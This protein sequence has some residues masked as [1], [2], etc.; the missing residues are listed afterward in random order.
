MTLIAQQLYQLFYDADHFLAD[1]NT[2]CESEKDANT[3]RCF[4]R[5]I[6][7]IEGNKLWFY[8]ECKSK[9][10]PYALCLSKRRDNLTYWG[11]Y[12]ATC[13]GI[14]LAVNVSTLDVLY[15]RTPNYIFGPSLF[16]MEETLYTQESICK[17]IRK[18]NG[19]PYKFT[20][21][22]AVQSP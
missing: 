1:L 18:H 12:A 4:Q 20:H 16:D 9:R 19:S 15:R 10:T 13:T 7:S 2:V 22:N 17:R 6:Q 3:K 8:K 5:F 21:R 11:R 14:C